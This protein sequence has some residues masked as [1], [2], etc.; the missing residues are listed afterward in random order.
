LAVV[1]DLVTLQGGHVWAEEA[2]GGGA[3]IVIEL[4]AERSAAPPMQASRDC[5]SAP[6]A[7]PDLPSA[8]P[9]P[10]GAARVP[11]PSA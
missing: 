7:A 9:Q 10:V 3:R 6:L 1:R 8:R 5:A 11:H 2:P 4:P